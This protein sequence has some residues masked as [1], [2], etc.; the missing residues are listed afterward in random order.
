[1]ERENNDGDERVVW[2]DGELGDRPVVVVYG[3]GEILV[4]WRDQRISHLIVSGT[5]LIWELGIRGEREKVRKQRERENWRDQI[6]GDQARLL[7]IIIFRG[8]CMSFTLMDTAWNE[9]EK[10]DLGTNGYLGNETLF[11]Q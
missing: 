1:M 3:P 6:G 9:T 10:S 11:N 4:A 5:Q 7:L 2:W 8:E